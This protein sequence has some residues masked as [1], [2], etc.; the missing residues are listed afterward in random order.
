MEHHVPCPEIAGRS[1]GQRHGVEVVAAHGKLFTKIRNFD[2]I[3]V[4]P[5]DRRGCILQRPVRQRMPLH[6]G[7]GVEFNLF[8]DRGIVGI[9]VITVHDE[10]RAF[11]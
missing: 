5:V 7:I 11:F 8:L 9:T 4:V 3:A 2:G 1:A 6:D 10:N